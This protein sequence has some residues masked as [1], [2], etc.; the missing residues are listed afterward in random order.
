[1]SEDRNGHPEPQFLPPEPP[2]GVPPG[3]P[4][5]APW[6]PPVYQPPPGYGP[7]PPGQGAPPA[8]YAP[9]PPYPPPAAAQ[10]LWRGRR[11]AGWWQRVGAAALDALILLVPLGIIGAGLSEVIDPGSLEEALE[12]GES[13]SFNIALVI[14]EVV[15]YLVYKGMLMSRRG[16]RN[17]QSWGMQVV[18]IRVVREDGNPV[19]WGTVA[20]RE[21]IVKALLFRIAAVLTLFVAT[22][23]NYLWPLWDD[24][25]RALHDMIARTRVIST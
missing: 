24:Q 3:Q 8:P 20:L 11:L 14:A 17:G 23:L 9:P 25:S 1:M 13:V 16:E 22:L 21:T 19:T 10:R 5:A 4:P 2:G 12:E 6:Q 15:T 18:G 7:P